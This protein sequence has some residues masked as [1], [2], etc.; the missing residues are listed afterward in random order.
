MKNYSGSYKTASKSIK[1]RT[2]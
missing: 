1:H 2:S